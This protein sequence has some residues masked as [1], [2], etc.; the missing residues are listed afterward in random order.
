MKE[1]TPKEKQLLKDLKPVRTSLV[2]LANFGTPGKKPWSS[3]AGSI[4]NVKLDENSL[5]VLTNRMEEFNKELRDPGTDLSTFTDAHITRG[6][7]IITELVG[8]HKLL[9]KYSHVKE[10]IAELVKIGEAYKKLA[11]RESYESS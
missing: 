5:V 3:L 6:V 2:N 11:E 10:L 1:R 9:N 4:G 7:E 8:M